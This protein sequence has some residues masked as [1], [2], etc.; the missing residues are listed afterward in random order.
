MEPP[1]EISDFLT[2][3]DRRSGATDAMIEES[4]KR[5]SVKLPHQYV[6]FLKLT[7]G[8]EGFVGNN[9]Y[10]IL[11]GIDELEHLNKGYKVQEYIP[12]L[13]MFGS[14]GGGEAYGFDMRIP[15]WPIVQVPFIPMEWGLARPLGASFYKFLEILYQS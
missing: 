3:L 5:L 12:G 14:D 8:A 1:S 10:A 6:E 2:G 15:D 11:W 4:Q 9:S 13:L 7:N